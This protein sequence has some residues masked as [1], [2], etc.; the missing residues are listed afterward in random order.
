M[1]I[2]RRLTFVAAVL[3]LTASAGAE[4]EGEKLFKTNRPS[5]AIPL[6]EQE[7]A[8]GSASPEAYNYL[9]L[10]YYQTGQYEKSAAVFDKGLSVPGTD[11]KILAYNAGNSAFAAG[12]YKRADGYFT[13]A[14]TASPDFMPAVLNRANTR[15]RLDDLPDALADYACYAEK[16][17]GD[18]Q[19]DSIRKVMGLIQ[20]E[21]QRREEE[22]KVAAEQEKK[23]QE[24]EAALKAEQERIAAEKAAKEAAEKAAEEERKKKLLEDVV[25]SLQNT[26]TENVT[27]GTEDTIQYQ[28]EP[29][30][31]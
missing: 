29:E 11:K 6:L 13:L 7:I 14:L 28:S 17:A 31:D 21:I 20:T 2:K 4:T 30:L 18:A 22:A 27:S 15:V 19:A 5:E 26:D 1:N 3:L 23:R 9:G 24:E 10:S 12:D 25:N 16:N 8:S